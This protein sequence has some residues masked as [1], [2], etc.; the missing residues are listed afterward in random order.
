MCPQTEFGTLF[1]LFFGMQMTLNSGITGQWS[2]TSEQRHTM[3]QW[4]PE[5]IKGS[6]MTSTSGLS[7]SSETFPDRRACGTVWTDGLH[8]GLSLIRHLDDC[9]LTP[10]IA[11][12]TFCHQPLLTLKVLFRLSHEVFLLHCYCEEKVADILQGFCAEKVIN[13]Y[14]A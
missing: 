13:L 9:N 12:D 8:D 10:Y 4:A 11:S 2:V 5:R 6:A 14:G 3:L 7:L 1:G